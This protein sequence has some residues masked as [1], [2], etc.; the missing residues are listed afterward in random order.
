[1]YVKQYTQTTVYRKEVRI[2]IAAVLTQDAVK[3]SKQIC[4]RGD[5][6]DIVFI[7]HLVLRCKIINGKR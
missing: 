3:Q 5:I 4:S 2:K 6:A 1:M 7:I